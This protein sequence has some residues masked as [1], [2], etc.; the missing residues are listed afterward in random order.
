MAQLAG[1]Y[2]EQLSPALEGLAADGSVDQ[3]IRTLTDPN[4]ATLF[5][6]AI[7]QATGA[8]DGELGNTPNGTDGVFVGVSRRTHDV[9]ASQVPLATEAVPATQPIN[10]MTKGRFWVRPETVVTALDS[11]VYYRHSNAGASPE[12]VGRFRHDNDAASGDVTLI[13]ATAARWRRINTAAGEGD[14]GLA[15]LEINLP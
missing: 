14:G 3:F 15:V 11:P 6:R 5:G 7:V 13:P 1:T 2:T 8:T 9:E 4:N 10:V 12:G